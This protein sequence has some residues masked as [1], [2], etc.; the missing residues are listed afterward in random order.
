MSLGMARVLYMESKVALH[1]RLKTA[2]KRPPTQDPI[3]GLPQPQTRQPE[4]AALH[5]DALLKLALV[6]AL[7]GLSGSYLYRKIATH[8][9]PAPVRLGSRCSR[10]RAGDVKQ[11]LRSQAGSAS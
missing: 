11:W 4:W 1:T 7:T 8:Q 3:P 10:W 9:F 2:A 5:D 6:V